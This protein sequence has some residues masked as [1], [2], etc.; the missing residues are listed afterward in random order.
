MSGP[1]FHGAAATEG[2]LSAETRGRNL[3]LLCVS[4]LTIMSGATISASL[5]GI[6]AHF[7]ETE[8]AALLSR[9]MLTLPAIFIAGLA[10]VAG[11]I[12]D[13]FGRKR[14]LLLSLVVFA[15][16]GSSGLVLD[17]LPALLVGRAVLGVSV[18]GIM[19]TATALVG[20]FFEGVA[21]DRYMGFQAA[22]VGIGGAIFLSGGGLLADIHWRGPFA[23]YCLAFALLPA[24]LAL[25]PEPQ[26]AAARSVTETKQGIRHGFALPLALVLLAACLHF[27]IF[28]MLPTQLPFY[29]KSL[30]ISQPSRAGIAIGAGQVVGVLAALSFSRVRSRIGRMGVFAL[31]FAALGAGYIGL[32]SAQSYAGILAA[33]AIT[34]ISMG[35]MT[36]NL[37]ASLLAIAPPALR[38]RLSGALIAAIFAGQFI[39]PLASQPLVRDW[40]YAAAFTSAGALLGA[41]ALVCLVSRMLL[42]VRP[43]QQE[44]RA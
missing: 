41:L 32:G 4:A 28:Y 8:G 18:A 15:L 21:R 24:V 40:G 9:L 22:F 37:S 39:S 3:T 13:R 44:D 30:G 42:A 11:V 10:P 25:I 31:G 33:T 6:E 20:D 34:G 27:A 19:T 23:I 36:P 16:A 17:S 38:G 7:V 43:R 29:L 12:A 26:R 1:T 35:M 5:P 2:V 14:L